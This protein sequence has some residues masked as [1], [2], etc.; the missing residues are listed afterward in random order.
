MRMTME[1]GREGCMHRVSL[2]PLQ[3]DMI[4]MIE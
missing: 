1:I 2:L 3:E 4:E